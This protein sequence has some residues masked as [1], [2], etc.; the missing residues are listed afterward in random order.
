ML[1]KTILKRSL[2]I[3]EHENGCWEP[4]LKPN[5]SGYCYTTFPGYGNLG[6]HVASCVEQHGPPPGENMTPDHTCPNTWCCN[7]DHL[8]WATRGEQTTGQKRSE[9]LEV[10]QI[11]LIDRLLKAGL[12]AREISE[13]TGVSVKRI[14]HIRT[15]WSGSKVTGR[16]YERKRKMRDYSEV[17]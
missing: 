7:P 3:I 8:K 2:T 16:V 4:A 12:K 5:G 15:G 14:Q 1:K 9:P 13:T 6:V 11:K 10:E 17:F